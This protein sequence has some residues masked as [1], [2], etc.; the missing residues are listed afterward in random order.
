MYLVN[1]YWPPFTQVI[2]PT[3]FSLLGRSLLLPALLGEQD[4]R[5]RLI[6]RQDTARLH[7]VECE[8]EKFIQDLPEACKQSASDWVAVRYLGWWA[9]SLARKKTPWM[10]SQ[11]LPLHA[12]TRDSRG[13]KGIVR[14]TFVPWFSTFELSCAEAIHLHGYF[15]KRLFIYFWL[16]WFFVAAHG[17][18]VVVLCGFLVAVVSLVAEHRLRSCSTWALEYTSSVVVVHGLGC[19]MTW[20]ILVPSPGI[21]P[22]FPALAGGFLTTEPLRKFQHGYS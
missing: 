17:L 22:I 9:S 16:H 14:D 7:R 13:A 1:P 11:T 18:S 21:K 2:F 20:W 15:L 3:P 8:K 12:G 6:I 19:S 5:S 10:K 4:L